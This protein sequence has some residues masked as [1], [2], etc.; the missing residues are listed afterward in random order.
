MKKRLLIIV[1]IVVAAAVI[2]FLLLN[3]RHTYAWQD[4]LDQYLA[5]LRSTGQP[6]YSLLSAVPSSMPDN[7]TPQMSAVSYSPSVIFE[8]SQNSSPEYASALLPMPYPPDEVWC[9][10]LKDGKQQ[11]LVYMALHNSLY[12]ADWIVHIPSEPWGSPA[13]QTNL[14]T[15]GCSFDI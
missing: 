1:P 4:N 7:F 12:N 5:Y 8:T 3:N 2:A 9:V 14:Q 13:L 10:L 15:L 6:S 11:Q